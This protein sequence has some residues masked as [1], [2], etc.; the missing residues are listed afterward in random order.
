MIYMHRVVMNT[1]DGMETDHIS[2]NTLDNRRENLRQCTRAENSA[3]KKKYSTNTSGYKGVTWHKA[4]NKWR[5]QITINYKNHI[6]GQFDKIE[7]AAKAYNEAAK[8]RLGEFARLNEVAG[9]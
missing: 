8:N 5:A 2:M 4:A 3:N 7:D 6:L 9:G 1:P